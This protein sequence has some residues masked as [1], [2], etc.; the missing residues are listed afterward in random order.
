MRTRTPPPTALSIPLPDAF[1][2][3]L[4]SFL[5]ACE[6]EN[7]APKTLRTYEEAVALL[8]RFLVDRGMPSEPARILIVDEVGD[9]R[10]IRKPPRCSSP[11]SAAAMN[12]A[13]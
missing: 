12:G 3:E 9:I 2:A 11:S 4:D 10:S 1:R 8:G 13:R 5:L 6:A 7:L